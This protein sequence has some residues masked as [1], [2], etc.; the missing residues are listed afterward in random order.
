[1]ALPSHLGTIFIH[2][3]M[4]M[5]QKSF[6]TFGNANFH[7]A[8]MGIV[9]ATALTLA[10]FSSL[11]LYVRLILLTL[12]ILAIYNISLSSQ[13]GYLNFIAGSFAALPIYL[14]QKKYTALGWATLIAFGLGVILVLLGCL[15][16]GPLAEAIY[17][18]SLQARG[19]Y[20]RVH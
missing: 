2:S 15:D 6:S 10:V 18:S 4:N 3:I 19:F 12:V 13:Q 7:S 5:P 8:F 1:M 9:A 20:W 11:K 17:K 14:F 16:K